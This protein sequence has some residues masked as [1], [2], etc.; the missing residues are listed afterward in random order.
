MTTEKHRYLIP[1]SERKNV[2]PKKVSRKPSFKPED[3]PLTRK[4]EL[5]VKTLVSEDGQ[6]TLKEAASRAGYGK[7]AGVRAS[8]LT[9]PEKCPHVC[10]AIRVYRDEL[11][12]KY[13]VTYKNHI[14]RLDDLSR[15]AQENQAWS[16]AVQAEYRRGLAHGDIYIDKK[17]VRHGKIDSMS[18]E[19]VKRALEEL[20]NTYDQAPRETT[21]SVRKARGEFLAGPKDAVEI[22]EAGVVIDSN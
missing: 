10:K 21:P 1:D 22:E 8:E 11:D 7:A 12:A 16:A 9:N 18:T 13:A 2:R 5:F 19:E 3:R 17:E 14:K 4:Q 20:K 6:I 15:G